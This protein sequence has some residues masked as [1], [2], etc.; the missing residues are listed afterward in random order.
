[1]QREADSTRT[2]YDGLLQ[3]YK[4]LGVAGATGT[5]NVAVI[6]LAQA[7]G[8]PYKPDLQK[9]LLMWFFLG[10]LGAGAAVAGRE[11]LDDTFKSPE[12]IEDQLGLAVLGLVPRVKE[13]IF[14][15]LR[16]APVSPICESYR[17]LRTALQFST[18]NGLPKSLI[19]TSPKPGEGKSTTAVALAINF[20]H[21]GMKVL[22]IDADLRNPS[23]HQLL[24]R[25][26]QSGLT[27][28]LVGGGVAQELLQTTDIPGLCFMASGPL[29]PNPAELLAGQNMARLLSSASENF[30]LVIIDA[31]PVLGLADAPLLA[32]IGAGT[33]LVLG[34]GET[35]RGVVKA[36]LKRLH[37]ARA[38]MVGAVLNKFDTRAANY[39]YHSYGYGE[40]QYYGYGTKSLPKPDAN[41]T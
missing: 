40:L 37:F 32:S 20:A 35:R 18:S 14:E 41:P 39:A 36:A 8:G 33:L 12:E 21:L 7:P 28:C 30:E 4:D 2:L 29:P 24:R 13:D 16:N 19:V 11:I 25:E 6:D 15:T 27:N 26:A 38:Q 5:N 22:L 23:A 3:Q 17:S 31:P 34:A 9:N 1:L 10:L